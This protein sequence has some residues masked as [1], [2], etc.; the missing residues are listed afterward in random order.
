MT[1]DPNRARCGAFCRAFVRGLI[2]RNDY[3]FLPAMVWVGLVVIITV[4]VVA[5][6]V[7]V[8]FVVWAIERLTWWAS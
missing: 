7:W 1:D 8:R 2:P 3:V 5:V 6:V 4:G